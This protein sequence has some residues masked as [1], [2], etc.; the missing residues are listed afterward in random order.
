MNNNL[1]TIFKLRQRTA[2]AA[3]DYTPADSKAQQKWVYAVLVLI[4]LV[5][6]GLRLVQI[7][8]SFVDKWS[9]R[10]ADVAM[11][12]ANF[13]HH[14]YDIFHPQIDW[15]GKAPGY[16]G[17]EFPLVPYLAAGL[18]GIV[19][20]HD[21]VGRSLSVFFFALSVP[22]LFA[23]VRRI[24]S[25]PRTALL[26]TAIYIMLPL[27]IF[28]G[29]SFMPDMASLTFSLAALW[30]MSHWLDQPRSVILALG[31]IMY[32]SL[33]LLIKAPAGIIGLPLACLAWQRYGWGFLKRW[34]LWLAAL[35]PLSLTAVWYIHAYLISL[36][37]PP[38]HDFGSGGLGLVSLDYYSNVAR[39]TFVH[40]LTPIV[41][42][43][44]LAGLFF[45]TYRNPARW[46]FHYWLAA[47]VFFVIIAGPGNRHPWYRLPL[48]PVAAALAAAAVIGLLDR[49]P[50]WLHKRMLASTVL[51]GGLLT[52]IGLASY[53]YAFAGLVGSGRSEIAQA[54]F[55]LDKQ[56]LGSIELHGKPLL[57]HRVRQ[58]MNRGIGL[59][60][61]DRKRQG[62]VLGLSCRENFALAMLRGFSRWGWMRRRQEE[63]AAHE[64]AGK[65]SV[66]TTSLE[67]P[68]AALSGGNQQ[69]I[70]LAKWLVRQS[71]LLI[72]DE[73]TR[74]V[75]VGAKA[76]IH[77]ILDDLATQGVAILL[78]SSELPE[79][80]T[81]SG[82][83]LVMREGQMVGSL[84]RSEASQ[85]RVL[86]L[87]AGVEM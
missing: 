15:A 3:L 5:G 9:W 49:L 81:L 56:A 38:Y 78:I 27:N 77:E 68:V 7:N 54:I 29:R 83:I 59:L 13:Y 70:A 63:A 50:R 17:T 47:I 42:L 71:K 55:G 79:L 86:R 65:L 44:A 11:I 36:E 85:E 33:A 25:C 87:M 14:G 41:S 53:Q 35:V 64:W 84:A 72:V 6:V 46:T 48:T 60:P 57:L 28:A 12:A 37:Y 30:A 8:Q 19:G 2:T 73:P 16:V 76:A 26:A 61:E 69:K 43:A 67:I 58:A 40:G 45:L 75:D 74:G 32:I 20:Q 31:T 34:E 52:M 4:V 18:Y 51:T 62:L 82:R 21:W 10:Q 22:L 23:L 39:I 80:L 24:S 1:A 66:K